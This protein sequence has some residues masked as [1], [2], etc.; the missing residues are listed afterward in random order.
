MLSYHIISNV[1]LTSLRTDILIQLSMSSDINTNTNN[2]L[3]IASYNQQ[4]YM[5]R[6]KTHVRNFISFHKK[7]PSKY[8]ILNVEC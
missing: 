3:Q 2:K 5:I 8:E 6:R 7:S 1:T 4:N